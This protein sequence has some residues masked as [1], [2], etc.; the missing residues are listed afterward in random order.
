MDLKKLIENIT[1]DVV[2]EGIALIGVLGVLY[3]IFFGGGLGEIIRLFGIGLC[4]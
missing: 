3:Y 4:G 1:I 2:A